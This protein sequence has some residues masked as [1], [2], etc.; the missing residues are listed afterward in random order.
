MANSSEVW[1]TFD[2]T[3]F[4]VALCGCVLLLAVMRSAVLK[5]IL[6]HWHLSTLPICPR[7]GGHVHAPRGSFSS[8][9][10]SHEGH[11]ENAGEDKRE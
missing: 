2:A 6:R 7:C 11:F 1:L 4:A 5:E 3:T 9:T 10:T 8:A